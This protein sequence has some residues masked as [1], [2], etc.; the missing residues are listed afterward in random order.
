MGAGDR[1]GS[2]TSTVTLTTNN[3]ITVTYCYTATLVITGNSF[4]YSANSSTPEL[5]VTVSKS[6]NGG[7]YQKI[8]D[9]F[10][11]TTLNGNVAIPIVAGSGITK[12]SITGAPNS[13][14]VDSF[15][16]EL[17]FVNLNSDQFANT[18]KSFESHLVVAATDC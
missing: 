14:I 3:K 15:K 1:T 5:V 2:T 17:S 16:A 8:L 12:H 10:D 18:G 6:A 9:N 7:E 4:E 11:I 13:T